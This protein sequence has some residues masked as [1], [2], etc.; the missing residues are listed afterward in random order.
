MV[1]VPLLAPLSKGFAGVSPCP[2]ARTAHPPKYKAMTD[3]APLHMWGKNRRSVH[4]VC[5]TSLLAFKVANYPD[6]DRVLQ[7]SDGV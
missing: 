7:L 2:G 1:W 4:F 5:I 6:R 3:Y